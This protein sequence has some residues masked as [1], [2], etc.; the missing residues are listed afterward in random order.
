ML[1]LTEVVFLCVCDYII[2]FIIIVFSTFWKSIL[3]IYIY[4]FYL[5]FLSLISLL[6]M[7]GSSCLVCPYRIVWHHHSSVTS[8]INTPWVLRPQKR[9]NTGSWC[10]FKVI[11]VSMLPRSL[12]MDLQS[13]EASSQLLVL[14]CLV[15]LLFFTSQGDGS[16]QVESTTMLGAGPKARTGSILDPL[17]KLCNFTSFYVSWV[18]QGS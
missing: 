3:Y 15:Q 8:Q 13:L 17:K 7:W 6:A 9:L 14:F 2:Y 5:F 1:Y 4:F 12:G 18:P 11:S 16:P 10:I